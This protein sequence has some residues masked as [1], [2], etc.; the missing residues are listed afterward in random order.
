VIYYG[1]EEGELA[2]QLLLLGP[3]AYHLSARVAGASASAQSLAWTVTCANSTG[4]IGR[5]PLD[6]AQAAQGWSFTVPENCPAQRL[7]LLG[8][9]SEVPQ[10]ADVT[11]SGLKLER[12]NG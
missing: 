9:M 12:V 11:I 3:G 8:T 1:Q 6:A 7:A 2:S 10:Q 4:T 5:F